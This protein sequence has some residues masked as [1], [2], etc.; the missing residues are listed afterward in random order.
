MKNKVINSNDSGLRDLGYQEESG[1]LHI[2][3]TLRI[4]THSISLI[5]IHLNMLKLYPLRLQ[6]KRSNNACSE[7]R[8]RAKV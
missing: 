7:I 4:K 8:K 3:F 6:G 1:V 2:T 5:N